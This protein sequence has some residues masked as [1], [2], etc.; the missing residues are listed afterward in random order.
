MTSDDYPAYK[1]AI[2]HVYGEEVTTTPTGR[3][4]AGGWCRRR[5][6]RRG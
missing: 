4:R 1:E 6:R 2:L 3:R 5:C